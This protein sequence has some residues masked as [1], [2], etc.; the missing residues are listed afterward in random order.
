MIFIQTDETA[1]TFS[2]GFIHDLWIIIHLLYIG[3]RRK[4]KD[5]PSKRQRMAQPCALSVSLNLLLLITSF[6]G[7]N[8]SIIN[9]VLSSIKDSPQ[10]GSYMSPWLLHQHKQTDNTSKVSKFQTPSTS[11][12]YSSMNLNSRNGPKGDSGPKA[13]T[14]KA[15]RKFHANGKST[16][17]V[18]EKHHAIIWC[19]CVSS[20]LMSIIINHESC[21]L[22]RGTAK[23]PKR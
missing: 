4:R 19:P 13:S 23:P 8:K 16:E 6:I 3:A 5:T 17:T 22:S 9:D 15:A 18:V 11:R 2:V 12:V 7:S 21:C 1:Y 10:N 20:F 14:H